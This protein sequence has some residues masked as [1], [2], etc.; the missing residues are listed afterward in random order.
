MEIFKSLNDL[1]GQMTWYC[2][3]CDPSKNRTLRSNLLCRKKN[4]PFVVLICSICR[5]G[6]GNNATYLQCDQCEENIIHPTKQCI[7]GALGPNLVLGMDHNLYVKLLREYKQEMESKCDLLDELECEL[8][9]AN[10]NN[11]KLRSK[12]QRLEQTLLQRGGELNDDNDDGDASTVSD[13]DVDDVNAQS[14]IMATGRSAKEAIILDDDDDDDIK[15]DSHDASRW[16]RCRRCNK[17]SLRNDDGCCQ[18][19]DA[20]NA[21]SL[22][23]K[24]ARGSGERGRGGRR[25]GGTGATGKGRGTRNDVDRGMYQNN[26]IL[27]G[28]GNLSMGNR[29]KRGR[30][31]ARGGGTGGI[32]RGRGRGRGGGDA[33]GADGAVM[34]NHAN[35]AKRKG[36]GRGRGR[37][38]T[39]KLKLPSKSKRPSKSVP[40]SQ[41]A[42]TTQTT[43]PATGSGAV[44]APQAKS[45]ASSN[46]NSGSFPPLPPSANNKPRKYFNFNGNKIYMN[47]NED[48]ADGGA[49]QL[50]QITDIHD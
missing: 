46:A 5:G 23:L 13:D 19:K 32:G 42:P 39:I 35:N 17:F 2:G 22:S 34:A 36:R 15:A 30:G 3:I 14:A 38:L 6:I 33:D 31:T 25:R 29:G 21:L 18:A 45:S 16:Q 27:G 8:L 41:S 40:S 47:S 26:D 1:K 12:L 7:N 43:L 11:K 4:S 48:D 20:I 24:P 9:N 37:K 28:Y 50:F 10:E 49:V 44:N